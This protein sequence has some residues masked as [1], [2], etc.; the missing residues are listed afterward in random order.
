MSGQATS[1]AALAA[2]VDVLDCLFQ[3]V[4]RIALHGNEHDEVR[5]SADTLHGAFQRAR[6]PFALQVL[7]E[8]VLRDGLPLPLEIEAHRRVQQLVFAFA[9]W[10]VVELVIEAPPEPDSLIEFAQA[11]LNATHSGRTSRAP[12]LPSLRLRPMRR[13]GPQYQGGEAVDDVF[14]TRQVTLALAA[15]ERVIAQGGGAWPWADG[16]AVVSRL[17]RC[18]LVSPAATGRALELFAPPLVHARR[19]LLAA[20]HVQAVL[21]QLHAGLLVQRA[22]AQALLILGV[23]GLSQLPGATLREAARAAWP[24][25]AA[26]AA[27]GQAPDPQR[28][29]ASALVAAALDA[30][31]APFALPVLALVSAAYEL[32]R[33]RCALGEDLHLSRA[34]LQ[35]WL[36]GEL[37]R[38]VH[39]G[40]GRALLEIGGAFP[41]GS[42]VLADGRLGVVFS[43]TKDEANRPRVLVGG[44]VTP[45]VQHVT[46]FSPLGMTPWAK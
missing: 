21:M 24:L 46:P 36:A 6:P 1:A 8:A 7:P 31:R 2:T 41:P 29:R 4:R 10:N 42:H 14:V 33:R 44:Q 39:A 13:P 30:E 17:E 16:R 38:E 43:P 18:L 12:R 40:W 45:A 20:F 23:Y 34:D 15:L 37:G 27:A 28:L 22:T 5:A 26:H 25:L 32:E 3:L 9:R 19:V 35:G 11:V